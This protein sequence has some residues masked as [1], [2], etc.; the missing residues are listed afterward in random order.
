MLEGFA[1]FRRAA[2]GSGLFPG[3]PGC[4]C[5]W[6][7]LALGVNPAYTFTYPAETLFATDIFSS[8]LRD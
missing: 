2:F 1:A 8:I 5:G 4:G 6:Y 7:A 3:L